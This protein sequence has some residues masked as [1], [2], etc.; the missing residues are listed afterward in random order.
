MQTWRDL[1][2]RAREARNSK[3]QASELTALVNRIM[4]TTDHG[5]DHASSDGKIDAEG[6]GVGFIEVSTKL[7]LVTYLYAIKV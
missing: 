7:Q 5:H 2:R 6:R 3:E 1:R 4:G